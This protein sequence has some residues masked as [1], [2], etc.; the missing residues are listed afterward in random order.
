VTTRP[1]V[2]VVT[3][4]LNRATLLE[5]TL[6]SVAAQT[7]PSVEHI[8]VDGGSTD[9]TRALLER[10]QGRSGLRW[11]SEPDDGMYSAVNKGLALARGEILAYLNSDDRYFPW[12]IATAVEALDGAPNAWFVFGDAL[13]LDLA[14]D[15]AQ[16]RLFPPLGLTHLAR[17]GFL[18]QPTVF[19]RRRAMESEGVFD[20]SL[21]YVADCDYWLRLAAHGSGVKVNEVLAL[22]LDH[23]GTHRERSAREV[24][25]ELAAVRARHAPSRSHLGP[26]AKARAAAFRRLYL[27]EL[28]LA[29]SSLRSGRGWRNF[30]SAMPRSSL[31]VRWMLAGLLPFVLRRVDRR[32]VR[33]LP[34]GEPLKPS[35]RTEL[36]H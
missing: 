34:D 29:V 35:A 21:R 28:A 18:S 5:G 6:E 31:S 24:W 25:D 1:L 13:A 15:R 32:I 30:V 17:S 22:E 33:R 27:L 36:A 16:L 23:E 12:T 26:V 3:P 9:G 2:S 11:V 10:W 8:V 20:E 4:T 7:Y 19:W 14:D